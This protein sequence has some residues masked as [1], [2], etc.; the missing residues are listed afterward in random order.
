MP[1]STDRFY[2]D[3]VAQLNDGRIMIVEYKGADRVTTDDTKEKR[4]VGELWAAK[5]KGK[6]M[7]VMG[8]KRNAQGLSLAG[9]IAKV[10]G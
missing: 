6:G 10:V 1:T 3:F 2:P 7:F 8:E 9:Q 4:N 5:S